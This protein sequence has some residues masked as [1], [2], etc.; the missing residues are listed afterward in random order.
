[1]SATLITPSL[2][3]FMNP[4][5]DAQQTFRS[6]LDACA[7]P[8]LP[9]SIA[10]KIDPPVGLT[11]ACASACLTLLDLD[12]RVWLQPSFDLIVRNWLQFHTGCRFTTESDR[13]DF[14]VI[15][16]ID[17]SIKLSHFNWGTHEQPEASTTLLIQIPSWE[18]GQPVTLTGYG[19]LDRRAVRPQV[20]SA[21]WDRWEANHRSYP[22]GVDVFFFTRDAAIGLPRTA[23]AVRSEGM[24]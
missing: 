9:Y 14:A 5:S 2:P 11:P 15:Q 22:L 19:I 16:Q 24:P 7:Q 13:A 8:G 1:M 6:L 17:D 4:V 12:V 18:E 21:F 23:R 3:G 20:N 10:V